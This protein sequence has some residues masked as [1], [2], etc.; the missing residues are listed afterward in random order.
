MN[1]LRNQKNIKVKII[2]LLSVLII[3]MGLSGCMRNSEQ[4]E[5]SLPA[6]YNAENEKTISATDRAVEE[7]NKKY[8]E[9]FKITKV[10]N[11]INT[12]SISMYACPKNNS[13]IVF[14][15]SVNKQDKSVT[16]DYPERMVAVKLQNEIENNLILNGIEVSTNALLGYSRNTSCNDANILIEEFFKTYNVETVLLHTAINFD[17]IDS[18]TAKNLINAIT[19]FSNKYDTEFVF[20]GYVINENYSKC[21]YEMKSLPEV[22]STWFDEY[23]PCSTVSFYVNDGICS[24]NESDINAA[25]MGSKLQ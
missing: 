1:I 17:C 15:V 13:D 14:T 22:T 6:G 5:N 9:E 4:L 25:L 3:S 8:G 16:D 18:G 11:R 20:D 23:N 21:R 2:C 19:E 12:D 7:L 24:Q 10:G